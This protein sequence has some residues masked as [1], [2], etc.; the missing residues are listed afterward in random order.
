[1]GLIPVS[2][3]LTC[4]IASPPSVDAEGFSS[5]KGSFGRRFIQPSLPRQPETPQIVMLSN[6]MGHIVNYGERFR[7]GAD[8]LTFA[9]G[10]P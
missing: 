7:A 4:K 1:M 9:D 8:E 10:A 5:D 6:N 2:Q 3:T